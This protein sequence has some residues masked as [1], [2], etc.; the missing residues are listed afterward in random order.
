[1]LMEEDECDWAILWMF[2]NAAGQRPRGQAATNRKD[3]KSLQ[4]MLHMENA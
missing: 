4:N 3:V 1:M 2:H